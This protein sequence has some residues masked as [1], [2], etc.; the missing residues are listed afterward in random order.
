VFQGVHFVEP[1]PRDEDALRDS[2]GQAGLDHPSGNGMAL[3]HTDRFTH[4]WNLI[5]AND[6]KISPEEFG[7]HCSTWQSDQP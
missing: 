7:R 3:Q 6:F 5:V 2:P 4:H 1:T